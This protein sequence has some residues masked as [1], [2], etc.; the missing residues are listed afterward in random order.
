MRDEQLLIETP[1]FSLSVMLFLPECLDILIDLF[2]CVIMLSRN[3]GLDVFWVQRRNLSH[4]SMEKVV[5]VI[6][7]TYLVSHDWNILAACSETASLRSQNNNLFLSAFLQISS[8]S[9]VRHYDKN[10]RTIFCYYLTQRSSTGGPRPLGGPQKYFRGG[11]ESFGWLDFVFIFPPQFF[12]TNWNFL[13][14][15]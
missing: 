3:T 1:V 9:E 11:R 15:H 2:I 7:K 8:F 14:A 10:E 4:P 12:S 6:E 13:N 5:K